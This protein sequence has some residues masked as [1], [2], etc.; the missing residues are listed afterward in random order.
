MLTRLGIPGRVC[1]RTLAPNV[2]E[3]ARMHSPE[4]LS[5]AARRG[6]RLLLG[7][8]LASV[9]SGAAAAQDYPRRGGAERQVVVQLAY[10]LGQAHALRRLC[11]GPADATWYGRMQRLVGQE[12]ADEA[13]RR[14]LVES[15]NAGY[16]AGQSEFP[17]CSR[18]SRAAE[19]AT[20]AHGRTLA[21]ALAAPTAAPQ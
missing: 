8:V 12:A 4:P 2:L 20:A 11:A 6:S 13:S 10:A 5:T 3:P 16:A 19:R 21:E 17:V 7:L 18:R 15:F 9:A 14:Q 1:V